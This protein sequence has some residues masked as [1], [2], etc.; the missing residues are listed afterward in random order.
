[1]MLHVRDCPGTTA[2]F[3]VCPF[4]WCRKVK[5]LLYHLVSC[6]DPT[7]CSICSNVNLNRN[8]RNLQGLN[9][10]RGVAYQEI[11]VARSRATV[12][13]SNLKLPGPHEDGTQVSAEGGSPSETDTLEVMLLSELKNDN[14][15]SDAND[16]ALN[17]ST[18]NE[19]NVPTFTSSSDTAI[20]YSIVPPIDESTIVTNIK[21]ENEDSATRN[22]KPNFVSVKI[23]DD[24]IESIKTDAGTFIDCEQNLT[25]VVMITDTSIV[26]EEA[27]ILP[28]IGSD[29]TIDHTNGAATTTVHNNVNNTNQIK[30]ESATDLATKGEYNSITPDYSTNSNASCNTAN[31]E[32]KM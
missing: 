30:V 27:M 17:K 13:A 2:S 23:E 19:K 14:E 20:D 24:V 9:Y 22:I 4:P 29:Q 31:V 12:E 28:T 1:M 11:L 15:S 26:T 3:D 25:E 21:I 18:S 8:M 6:S 5:H 32:N 7:T 10:H 16:L